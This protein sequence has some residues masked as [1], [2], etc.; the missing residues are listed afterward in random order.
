MIDAREQFKG[1][2]ESVKL[3]KPFTVKMQFPKSVSDG[4]MFTFFELL[5]TQTSVSVVDEIAFQLDCWAYDIETLIEMS[6]KASDKLTGVGFKRQFSSPDI[7]P[8]DSG[9]YFRKT[10]RFGRKVDT[11]TN[12]LID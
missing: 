8:T 7:F 3:S 2:L 12:R 1:I 4:E 10:F 11:R 9:G 6:Q 5:N